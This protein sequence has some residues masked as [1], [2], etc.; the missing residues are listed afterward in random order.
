MPFVLILFVL[1]FMPRG[2]LGSN[3]TERV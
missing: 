2:L 1:F 3:V